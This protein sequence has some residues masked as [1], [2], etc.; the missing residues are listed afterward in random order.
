MYTLISRHADSHKLM[1]V[2]PRLE[3]LEREG[4]SVSIKQ[5]TIELVRPL[6]SEAFPGSW[7]VARF[8]VVK[9]QG[10]VPLHI[11]KPES[12]VAWRLLVVQTNPDA[13]VLHDGEW[14]H[15]EQDGIY[16]A[17]PQRRHAAVNFGKTQRVHLV[18]G[19]GDHGSNT[20][21]V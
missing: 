3:L 18:V 13:W 21:T 8:V 16:E 19:N 15:L 2:L 4:Y 1:D 20:S 10:I 12:G 7:S 11:D 14:Q 6:L 17:E 5:P 9:P